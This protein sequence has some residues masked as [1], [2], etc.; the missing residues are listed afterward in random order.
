[1]LRQSHNHSKIK[2]IVSNDLTKPLSI[3]SHA[4]IYHESIYISAVQGFVP[5][6]FEFP[7]T[8]VAAEAEQMMKNLSVILSDAGSSFDKLLKITLY[9]VNLKNDFLPVNEVVNK[10]IPNNSPAR[11]SI[12]VSGLPRGARVV[13]DCV[14]AAC[15]R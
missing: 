12:E 9:F 14:A 2:R 15:E 11:S 7:Q 3:Y 6:T 4:V 13:I 10:Y 1:M 5:G 8:G